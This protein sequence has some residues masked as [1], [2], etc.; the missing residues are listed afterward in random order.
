MRKV[1]HALNWLGCSLLGH[2]FAKTEGPPGWW[3]DC[4]TP[5]RCCSNCGEP[6]P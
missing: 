5:D 2:P 4:T 3:R 1:L 6:V